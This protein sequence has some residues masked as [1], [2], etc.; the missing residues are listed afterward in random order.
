MFF[1]EANLEQVKEVA[2]YEIPRNLGR[3]EAYLKIET[4]ESRMEEA[5]LM[6]MACCLEACRRSV[7]NL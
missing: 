7:C 5:N 1:A 2:A 3:A 4:P 6:K